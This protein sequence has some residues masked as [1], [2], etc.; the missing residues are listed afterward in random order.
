MLLAL[1]AGSLTVSAQGGKPSS[2]TNAP[3]NITI[4]D[5]NPG[6]SSDGSGTYA[7][8]TGGVKAILNCNGQSIELSGIRPSYL[9]VT[10]PPLYGTAPAW[11]NSAPI[12]FFN[13]PLG[14]N[15][16]NPQ[17]QFT[18]YLKA[19]MANSAGFFYMENPN[20]TAPLNPADSD[21]N[22]SICTTS[23]VYVDHYP[24]GTYLN[25][26]AAPETWDVYSDLNSAQCAGPLNVSSVGTAVYPLGKGNKTGT[27][28]YSAP[29][30]MLVQRQ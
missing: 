20:A 19:T 29:F 9:N 11:P 1:L 15:F 28:Q 18:T 13:I 21:V 23:L 30:H 24:A 25:N 16:N 3:V 4:Q 8:G 2:C 10:S 26:T 27:A 5:F 12:A 14:N 6:I 22:N 17:P 7:N